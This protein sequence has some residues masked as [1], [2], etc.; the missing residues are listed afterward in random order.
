LDEYG[1]VS[2]I[3]YSAPHEQEHDMDGSE[4]QANLES[5]GDATSAALV[6]LSGELDV[7]AADL[8]AA[9]LEKIDRQAMGLVLDME[10][11]TFIDSS[12]LRT[13]IQAR[14]M[15]QDEP[16][17]VTIRNPQPATTRLLELT[18]LSEYFVVA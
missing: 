11:V 2:S 10:G 15:F 3:L 6:V 7:S 14:Q 18:G 16:S 13:L 8:L 4:F 12:G 5:R 9:T 17:S 1:H